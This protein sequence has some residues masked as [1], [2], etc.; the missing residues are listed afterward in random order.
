MSFTEYYCRTTKTE[1]TKHFEKILTLFGNLQSYIIISSCQ[2]RTHL[3][4]VTSSPQNLRWDTNTTSAGCSCGFV[5]QSCTHARLL[6][7][8]SCKNL[9]I[10]TCLTKQFCE[11]VMQA[12]GLCKIMPIQE[13][14][15]LDSVLAP[16]CQKQYFYSLNR[17]VNKQALRSSSWSG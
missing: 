7:P 15:C 8:K 9:C 14:S 12:A 11:W 10:I 6:W 1:Y 13:V 5:V 2:T 17:G 4:T 3:I 16:Q